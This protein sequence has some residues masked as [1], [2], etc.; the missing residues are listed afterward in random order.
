LEKRKG[1]VPRQEKI[2]R[3][4]AVVFKVILLSKEKRK[5]EFVVQTRT[6]RGDHEFYLGRKKKK[7][8]RN[9]EPQ[10]PI[11]GLRGKVRF[12]LRGQE[13]GGG[14]TKPTAFPKPFQKRVVVVRGEVFAKEEKS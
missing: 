3:E 2:K 9:R 7:K 1:G 12:A 8:N 5:N 6:K 11:L 14:A 4:S 10:A 13:E